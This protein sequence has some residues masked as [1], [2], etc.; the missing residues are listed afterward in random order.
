MNPT[1]NAITIYLI[2]VIIAIP[3]LMLYNIIFKQHKI[4]LLSCL[5]SYITIVA[6]MMAAFSNIVGSDNDDDFFTEG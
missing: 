4:N 3:L 6:C 1:L 5:F 2:G